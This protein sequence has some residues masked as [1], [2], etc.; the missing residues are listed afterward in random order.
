[1][2]DL[3]EFR[4]LALD[5]IGELGTSATWRV[6]TTVH[7]D[8]GI[9]STNYTSHAVDCTDMVDESRRYGQSDAM[10]RATGTL[11]VAFGGIDVTPAI[12]H[13]VTY[14]SRNW[15]VVAVTAYAVTGADVM[16]RVDVAE[17]GAD[18]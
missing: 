12:G 9:V 2:S 1:M 6:P 5:L 3:S 4:E 10:Q 7:A 8:D 17:T 16:W 13:Q 11:Y 15:T 18:V 14:R